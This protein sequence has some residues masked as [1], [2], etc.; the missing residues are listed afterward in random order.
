MV[1]GKQTKYSEILKN[2]VA[3]MM[4]IGQRTDTSEFVMEAVIGS[5]V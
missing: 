5:F 4:E 3:H 1:G 2:T